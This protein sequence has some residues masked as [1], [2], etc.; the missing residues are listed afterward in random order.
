MQIT[1]SRTTENRGPPSSEKY[2][3]PQEHARFR[4]SAGS[5]NQPDLNSLHPS[6]RREKECPCWHELLCWQAHFCLLP[7]WLGVLG[8]PSPCPPASFRSPFRLRARGQERSA[9]L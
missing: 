6:A 7:R 1:E 5:P 9:A 4:R 3:K 8:L 2:H